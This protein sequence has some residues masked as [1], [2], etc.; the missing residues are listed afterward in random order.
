[1]HDPGVASDARTTPRNLR[2]APRN[3]LLSLAFSLGLLGLKLAAADA[4]A[5][6]PAAATPAAPKPN[7]NA[8]CLESHSDETLAMKKAG[9]KLSLFIDEKKHAGSAHKALDCIDC[10]EK[11]DGDASPHRKPMVAVDCAGCH[12]NTAKKH[13]FHSRLALTPIPE[14][15]D[16][17]CVSCH[18]KHDIAAV[19]SKAFTFFA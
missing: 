17:S 6:N 1:M 16:T 5:E 18:G 3:F 15:K 8:A 9:V 19:K 4:P 10:H 14:G 11:F 12:E 2:R 7:S 13:A